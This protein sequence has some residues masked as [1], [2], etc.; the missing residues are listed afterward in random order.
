MANFLT[1]IIDR[2]EGDF[3]VIKLSGDQEIYWPKNLI[4]FNFS[5]GDQVNI[6]L[7]KNEMETSQNSTDAKNL[8]RRI[9]QPN[10]Q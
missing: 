6:Y 10:A 4:E 8:L 3:L 1:G 5:A 7:S 2:V 9:F